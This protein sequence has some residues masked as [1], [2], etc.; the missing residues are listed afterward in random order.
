MSPVTSRSVDTSFNRYYTTQEHGPYATTKWE[1]RRSV[2][3][4]KDGSVVFE[5]NDVVVPETW[6]Q[7]A[8]DI[9]VSKYFR[10]GGVPITK[11]ER[12][13]QQVVDRIVGAIRQSGE[14]QGGYFASEDEADLF[15]DELTYM[16]I[17]QIGA[18]NSPVWFNTGLYESYGIKGTPSGRWATVDGKP[19]LMD[20]DYERPG[21]SACFIQGIKDDLMDIAAHTTREMRIFKAGGGSGANYSK[22]RA[23]GEPLSGGGASSGVMSFLGIFDAAAGATKS[24]GTTR[25]AARMVILDMDHPDVVEFIEWKAKEEDK[26]VAL[27]KAGY[28]ADLDGEAYKTVGGQNANNSVRATDAFMQAVEADGEWVTRWRKSG[29]PAQKYQARDLMRKISQAAWRCADPGMQFHDTCN[30]WNTVPET[31]KINA[32]NPCAEFVFLDDTSCNLASLNLVKFL[33]EDGAFDVNGFKHACHIFITAQEILVD[34]ASYPTKKIASRSHRLRP[35]GLGYANLGGLLMR[36]GYAYDSLDGRSIAGAITALMCGSA[37]ER[38]AEIAA[39]KGSFTAFGINRAHMLAVAKKHRAEVKNIGPMCDHTA[40]KNAALSSWDR[41]LV[42]GEA[43]GYRNAQLT[44]LAPTGTIGLL[45][46][47]DTTGIEPD[48]ALVK[49]KK[50]AGGGVFKIVNQS[51]NPALNNLGYDSHTRD[52]ICSYVKENETIEGA[53]GLKDKH[54]AI[55]DCASKCGKE[56]KRFIRPMGHVEMM[57]AAQPFLCGAISK[58]VNMPEHTTVEQIEAIYIQSW[59]LGIKSIAIYRDK[60][61]GCQVL[62]ATADEP[63]EKV[64]D[65]PTRQEAKRYRL[66]KRRGGFTQEATVAGHKVFLRTGEYEDGTLGEIFIDMHKEG[67]PLRAWADCFAIAISLGLQYGVPVQEF[68]DAFVFAKFEPAG[69][70]RGDAHIRTATSIPD[71]IFRTIAIEYLNRVDLAHVH[72]DKEVQ[73]KIEGTDPHNASTNGHGKVVASGDLCHKCQGITIRSGTCSVCVNCAETS[74]CS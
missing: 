39:I 10:K 60:S 56:G 20:N 62:N 74:G 48:Y 24:G 55:F 43:H 13:A 15:Q 18:F 22:I 6:S 28:S 73:L 17:N 46:D 64:D 16:L 12:S 59:K 23:N 35:L 4:N 8:T 7:L 67:A 45:M 27:V 19:Q 31:G 54:L 41:A 11:T 53:P 66:P 30:E 1:K 5:M 37:W 47:C 61:K 57:A 38:S 72:P 58:T 68:V 40:I 49:H 71:Y 21:I 26:I 14:E 36:M 70:V 50:L 51:I 2:I 63:N 29:Q 65:E 33:G 9:I 25:R 44:V 34:H 52:A 3:A 69:I 32:T 42:K